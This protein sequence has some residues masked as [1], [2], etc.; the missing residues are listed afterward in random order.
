MQGSCKENAKGTKHGMQREC[1]NNVKRM[2]MNVKRMK[3]GMRRECKEDVKRTQ[4]E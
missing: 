4:R 2:Q 1:Q 3:N